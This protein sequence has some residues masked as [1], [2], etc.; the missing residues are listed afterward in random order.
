MN[1]DS[2]GTGEGTGGAAPW[3]LAR[4]AVIWGPGLLVMLADTDAGNVVT[5][6]Q[7][8]AKWGFRLAPLTLALIPVLFL[9]QDIALRLGLATGKGFGAL[10]RERCGAVGVIVAAVA[11][12]SATMSSLVTELSGIA[13]VGEMYGASR[14]LIAP[15]AAATLVMVALTGK[16]RRIERIALLFGLFEAAFL[17]VVWRSQPSFPEAARQMVDLPLREPSFL[18]LG[19]ALIGATF[20]PWMTFYQ[21]SAVVEKRLNMGDYREARADTLLGAF[22]TQG[23]TA[24]ILIAVAALKGG[25]VGPLNSIGEISDALTPLLGAF[26]GRLVFG[27]G[28]VGASL[29]AAIVATLACAWGLRELFQWQGDSEASLVKQRGFLGLYTLSIFG[30]AALVVGV[31]DLVGLSVAMQAVNAVLLPVV[32][33]LL[34]FLGAQALPQV[35]RF[36]PVR[37]VVTAALLGAVALAGL[38]GATAGLL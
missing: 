16:Y 15:V 13:G 10:I 34:I 2:A 26:S 19:A 35:H 37:L 14:F 12:V 23:L 28:V 20:N 21:S 25:A 1:A 22:I 3:S 30:A 38:I 6:A 5:A 7:A 4:I 29:A 36:G 27:L 24:S 18:Y 9:L 31:K 33:G 32:G 17:L 11:L 8:G